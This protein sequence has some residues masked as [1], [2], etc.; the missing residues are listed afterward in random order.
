MMVCDRCGAPRGMC[1][2]A[3]EPDYALQSEE[4]YRWDMKILRWTLFIVTCLAGVA[5]WRILT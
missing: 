1:H 5:I 2:H 3:G 4:T